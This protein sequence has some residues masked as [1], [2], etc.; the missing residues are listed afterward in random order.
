MFVC[1]HLLADNITDSCASVTAD[2]AAAFG[3]SGKRRME[4]NSIVDDNSVS[5]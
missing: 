5:G 1:A 4:G 2:G 3:R